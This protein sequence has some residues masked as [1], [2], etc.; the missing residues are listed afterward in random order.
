MLPKRQLAKNA[1]GSRLFES[2]SHSREVMVGSCHNYAAL[3]IET[4]IK[5]T[6][7]HRTQEIAESGILETTVQM[8]QYL[9][10]FETEFHDVRASPE[11]DVCHD[12]N[13]YAAGQ[14]LGAVLLAGGSSGLWYR[15]VRNPESE[16][17]VC[18]SPAL[19]NNVRTGAHFE[20]RWEGQPDPKVK[21]ISAT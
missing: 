5:E 2:L 11:F 12:P 6:V 18:F 15:S 10:D 4:A 19:V 14:Q 8:R 7:F 9:A 1:I 13:S 17:L 16:C 3:S 21:Q 20:Y